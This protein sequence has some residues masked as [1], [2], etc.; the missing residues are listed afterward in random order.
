MLSRPPTLAWGDW[1][2]AHR[3]PGDRAC[4]VRHFSHDTGVSGGVLNAKQDTLARACRLRLNTRPVC[5]AC[6]VRRA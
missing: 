3:L 1:K 5:R 4:Q 2:E 6:P